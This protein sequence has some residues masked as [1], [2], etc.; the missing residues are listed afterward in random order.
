MIMK[1][2]HKRNHDKPPLWTNRSFANFFWMMYFHNIHGLCEPL[3]VF[4]LHVLRWTSIEA[5]CGLVQ[6]NPQGR[7]P[8][9][10]YDSERV[11]VTERK[12][13]KLCLIAYMFQ[14]LLF[15]GSVG[16]RGCRGFVG[17]YICVWMLI[18][19]KIWWRWWRGFKTD[20]WRW[21]MVQGCWC[22]S[23]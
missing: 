16:F 20:N 14:T 13:G 19:P 9:Q 21:L 10:L 6:S 12:N 7:D 17:M 1:Y 22:E 4:Q 15:R 11:R 8:K 3:G 5:S 18:W 2:K 23:R